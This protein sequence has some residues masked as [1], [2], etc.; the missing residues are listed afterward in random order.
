[1]LNAEYLFAKEPTN[2]GY[3][4]ALLKNAA[5]AGYFATA[6]FIAPVL[7]ELLKREKKPNLSRFK[8]FRDTAVEAAEKADAASDVPAAVALYEQ[9]VQSLD[10]L[11][12]RMPTDDGLRNEQRDMSS[13]LTIARGKYVEA[14]S[15]RDSLQDAG[16]QKILHDSDRV[17]QGEQT[18]DDLVAAARKEVDAHPDNPAKINALADALCK[19]EKK[20][21]EAEAIRVLLAAQERTGNYAFKV[22][23]DDI[24]LRQLS[25]QTRL[26]KDKAAETGSDEDQQQARLS[27]MEERSAELEICRERTAKYPT[28]LRT[29]YRLGVAL[30]RAGEYDEAIPVLQQAQQD[31]RSKT[32]CL[33]IMGRCFY[34]KGVFGQTRELLKEALESHEV[35]GDDLGKELT[36]WLGRAYE[37]EGNKAEA[38]AQYGKL[39]RQDYN[40][41]GGDARTRLESLK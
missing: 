33:L 23:A 38:A 40:Y 7:L 22:R 25:R 1:M 12:A 3:A 16:K 27:E 8:T 21:E 39:L 29:K 17:Q 14:D 2:E 15:F 26:L 5:K 35:L 28:D 18:L 9:A 19:R 37:A 31:P 20:S 30:F 36:Y 41:A 10:F 34:E 13:K 24:H 11:R 32:R 4:E 6:R